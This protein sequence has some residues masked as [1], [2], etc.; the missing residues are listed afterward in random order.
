MKIG[1]EIAINSSI[2]SVWEAWTKNDVITKWFP[3]EANIEP[4]VG[5]P[6]ELFFDRTN[7]SH[8]S[9]QGCVFTKVE[10]FKVLEFTWKGPGQ[11][12]DIM[13]NPSSLTTV[14]VEFS[15]DEGKTKVKFEHEGWGT[16]S[17]WNN[18][19][20]WHEEQW[21]NVLGSLKKFLES[22]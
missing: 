8:E 13:N 17:D 22:K 9:T 10:K 3:P 1:L 18:A 2:D 21:N 6:F 5:G 20:K 19:R 12:A 11:F 14:K 15:K 16:S 4:R 7:H